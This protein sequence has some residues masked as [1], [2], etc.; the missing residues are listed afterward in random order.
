[1]PRSLQIR[2]KYTL[3]R[4]VGVA[5]VIVLLPLFVFIALL[6]KVDSSGPIFF[7]QK[8]LGLGARP[9]TIWKFRSMISDADRLLDDHGRIGNVNRITRVGRFLRLL[10][11]DELP[12]VINIAKGEMSLVGPRPTLVEH[13]GRYTDRQRD[14]FAMKPGVTGLAQASGRNTLVW[15]RRIKLDLHYIENYSLWMDF[16]VIVKTAKV[17]F[18]GQGLVLDRKPE[19]VDDL[20]PEPAMD[21]EQ[22]PLGHLSKEKE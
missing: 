6:I 9:F 5:L 10:S 8:R 16:K 2:L 14:R 11:L 13:L 3:D 1:M 19:Q 7:R 21:G 20:R 18:L 15:S 12:Q 17:V 22:A 4:L